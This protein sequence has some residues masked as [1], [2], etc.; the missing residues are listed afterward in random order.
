MIGFDW[1]IRISFINPKK[2]IFVSGQ[3]FHIYT[4]EMPGGYD[5]GLFPLTSPPDT[6]KESKL[7][8]DGSPYKTLVLG[9]NQ[10]YATL[11][12]MTDYWN[13]Q[14]S[15]SVLYVQDLR[16]GSHWVKSEL[17]FKIGDHWRPSIRYLYID[18]GYQDS[19]FSVYRDR[20]E[21]ALQIEYQF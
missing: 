7:T 11:L 17:G 21:I 14:I 20:D 6:F 18:G 19:A 5:S 13:E 4:V 16:T 2:N 15:P 3:Y 1:P 12:L 8:L 10:S 9:R